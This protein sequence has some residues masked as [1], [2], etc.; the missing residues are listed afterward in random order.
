MKKT[1]LLKTL[2]VAAALCTGANAWAQTTYFSQ[3]YEADGATADW[4]T[5]TS[6]RFT[7]VILEESGNHYL[8]VDQNTRNNNGATITTTSTQGKVAANTDFTMTFD[9]RLS[10]STDQTATEFKIF[11]AANSRIILSLKETGTYAKTWYLNNSQTTTVELPNSNGAKAIADITW[12]SYRISRSNG[13]TYLTITEKATGSAVL[14][15]TIVEGTSEAGG[16]G[17]MQFISSRYNANFGI[18]NIVIRNV[19]DDDVPATVATTYTIKYVDESNQTIKEDVVVN[20]IAGIEVKASDDQTAAIYANDKKYIYKSGN[21]TITTVEDESSNVITLVYREAAV[22]N[23]SVTANSGETVVK[24]I[25]SGTAFEGDQLT[26]GYPIYILTED[27]ALLTKGATSSQYRTTFTVSEENFNLALA[28]AE[29]STSIESVIFYTEGEDIAGVN[30]YNT[31]NSQI[32]SSN[33]ASAYTSSDV[34]IT[35]LEAGKYMINAVACI[36]SGSA[37]FIFKAGNRELYKLSAGNGNW[38]SGNG[39]F[40]LAKESTITFHGGGTDKGLDFVYIQQLDDPTEAELAEAAAADVKADKAVRVFSIVGANVTGGWE[41]DYALTQSTKEGEEDIYTLTL[42][43]FEAW[44]GTTYEYKLRQN[45]NWDGYQLPA[46]SDNA[47]F[48]VDKGGVYRL[49]FTADVANN[50]IGVETILTK[51]YT[52]TASYTNTYNWGTVY[53]Y[54]WSGDGESKVEQLGAWPGTQLTADANGLYTAT[55]LNKVA[56]EYI[57][58]N[59]NDGNQTGD[60][61]FV[62][63]SIYNYGGDKSVSINVTAAGYATYCSK[64][65]LDFTDVEGVT[66]YRAV[67]DASSV[68][69]EKVEKV[70]AGEGIL[71]KAEAGKYTVP[72]IAEAEAIENAFEGV[73]EPKTIAAGSFVLMNGTE[74]VG[75]YKTANEFTVG[76]NTAYLPA[77]AGG[78]RSYIGFNFEDNTTTAIEGVATVKMESGAVYNLQGQRVESSIFNVQS[79]MLKKGLYIV[80]GKKVLVK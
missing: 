5:A 21:E 50:T 73:T 35:T 53:A 44:P 11:D 76:A 33:G 4:T 49:I 68:S 27:G 74:G 52:Y 19:Q 65:A 16:I 9:M 40:V 37:S 69:F 41:N 43:D 15:R 66:A 59:A 1:K 79:S 48:T 60:L 75:F 51:S 30:L 12:L 38:Q 34:N 29:P 20:S 8:S 67:L 42:N 62:D 3:D 61:A 18:D 28:Y 31:G 26:V 13:V 32:R 55:I 71:V 39:E 54:T 64:L 7:P 56:P 2:L 72:S 23:Y 47:S 17:K 63:G 24:T 14:E 45:N 46:G 58:F 70:P 6:G 10:S 77:L 25:A 78:A 36:A 22:W 57:I 80:N